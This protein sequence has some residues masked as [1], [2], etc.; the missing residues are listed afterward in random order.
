LTP[1]YAPAKKRADEEAF[2][3]HKEPSPA[4]CVTSNVES[5]QGTKKEQ[6][7]AQVENQPGRGQAFK[8]QKRKR[9]LRGTDMI[10]SA[11]KK[12][13]KRLLPHS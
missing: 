7:H 5:P 13:V 2:P 10:S 6:D 3:S 9:G 8:D 1:K 4:A 11:D 12:A